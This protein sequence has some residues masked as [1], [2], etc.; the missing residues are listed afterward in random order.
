[1]RI[2][3]NFVEALSEV[4]RDL[5]EMGILVHT[6]SYQNKDISHD[7]EYST[8]EL[9]NYIYQ[10][11][12]PYLDDLPAS[13]PWV[14]L[15]FMER[16]SSLPVNPGTAYLTRKDVWNEFLNKEGKFDYTYNERLHYGKFSQITQA[17]DTLK[18]D[19]MSRQAYISIWD[20]YDLA[21]SGGY[22]RIPCSLGYQFQIRRDKLN[23][24]Y[25]QRS[26]DYV[27]HFTN[28]IYLAV[29]LQG[30]IANELRVAV[31]TYTHW[32]GSLHAFKKDLSDVF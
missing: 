17:I 4:R 24:T 1:M 18:K 26:S 20:K 32:I 13:K 29:K 11:T 28:D 9:Q 23:I 5:G 10:V 21:D 22:F 27:T 3:R 6:K 25:L 12:N 16:I 31:G 14:E 19:P 15:E 7:D 2:Y 8:K 30:F